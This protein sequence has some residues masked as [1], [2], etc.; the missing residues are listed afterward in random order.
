MTRNYEQPVVKVIA[1]AV[2]DV[3]TLSDDKA[4]EDLD[5]E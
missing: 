2:A 1:F 3:L 4:D 5:W